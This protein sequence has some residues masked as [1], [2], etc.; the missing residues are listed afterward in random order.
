MNR[1]QILATLAVAALAASGQTVEAGDKPFADVAAARRGTET[2]D[3]D[4]E[5]GRKGLLPLSGLVAAF[6]GGVV[7]AWALLSGDDS[8]E[9]TGGEP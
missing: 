5:S 4:E 3:G 2:G 6:L 8:T 9:S 1:I 7:L